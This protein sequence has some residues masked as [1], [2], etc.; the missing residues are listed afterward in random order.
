MR[1]YN[2]GNVLEI[3]GAQFV[4]QKFSQ[5]NIYYFGAAGPWFGCGLTYKV[6]MAS[7]VS[8]PRWIED[9]LLGNFPKGITAEDVLGYL[10]S[11]Q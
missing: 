5:L 3:I 1:I 11:S 10:E 4:S 9:I 6:D 2:A 8:A 7:I